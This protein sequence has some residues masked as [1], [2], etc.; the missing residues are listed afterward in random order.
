[1]LRGLYQVVRKLRSCLQVSIYGSP[2]P[3]H[4]D[5]ISKCN[6]MKWCVIRGWQGQGVEA[7]LMKRGRVKHRGVG[8]YV[9]GTTS[10][11]DAEF[12]NFARSAQVISK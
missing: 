6:I 1:M 5:V 7:L 9:I 10:V 4:S 8:Y 3:S 11:S 12:L 2:L